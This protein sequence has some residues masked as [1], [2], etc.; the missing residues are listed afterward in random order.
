M[1]RPHRTTHR[2]ANQGEIVQVLR[3]LG[4]T[5][6]DISP[7]PGLC[8]IAVYGYNPNRDAYEWMMFEIKTAAGKLTTEQQM[9]IDQGFVRLARS[10][11]DVLKAFRRVVTIGTP[12]T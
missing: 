9:A 2:D 7:L 4:Y 6:W 12:P 5:V 8:D 3:A 10:V 11:D 1:S